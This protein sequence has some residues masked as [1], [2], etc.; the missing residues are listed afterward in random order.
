MRYKIIIAFFVIMLM[1][2]TSANSTIFNEQGFNEN[3][4]KTE[5]LSRTTVTFYS[6]TSDG[7]TATWGD[8]YN[9]IWSADSGD[10]MNW[11]YN[12]C[13]QGKSAHYQIQRA[14][15]YFD[16]SS[17]PD[18]APILSATLSL[19]GMNTYTDIDFYI[20]V[21]NGQPTYPHDPIQEGDYD[22]D[23]YS[24][25]GGSFHTSNFVT[26]AYNDI[27]LNS[28]GKSWIN[29]QGQTKFCLRSQ[30]EIEG[31][32]PPHLKLEFVSFYPAEDGNNFAPKLTV[33]YNS[34]PN[35]PSKPTGSTNGHVDTQYTY[36]STTSDPDNDN[37]YYW[38]DWGDGTNSGWKGP[39]SSGQPGS[40]S[41][42]WQTPGSYNVKV[43]SK[44]VHGTESSWSDPLIVTI[45]NDPP[46]APG[47]PNGP[48]SGNHGVQYCYSTSAT[49]PENQQVK[50]YFDWGDG[51]GAWT[52]FVNSGDSVQKCHT[53]SEP[54]SYNVKAKAKDELGEESGWSGILNVVLTNQAPNI[55]SSPDPPPGATWVSTSTD[56][57]WNGGDP[58]GDTVYYDVYFGTTNPPGKVNDDQTSTTY[59]P[60]GDLEELTIYYWQI[61]AKD[62][63]GYEVIGPI[64]SFTTREYNK[65]VLKLY[66]GWP[67][68]HIP[69]SGTQ[70]T[71]FTF[72]INYEDQDG[73]PPVE[74]K[75]IFN[76]GKEY[77]MNLFSGVP[78][79]GNYEVVIKGSDVGGGTHK[80]WFWYKDIKDEVRFPLPGEEWAIEVNHQPNKPTIS[81]PPNGLPDVEYVYSAETTD[82]E[83][84][85]LKYWFDWGDG[86]NS[87]WVPYDEWTSSGDMVSHPHTWS[88]R[89]TY[90]VK[91]RAMDKSEDISEWSEPLTVTMPRDR[92]T[93]YLIC[94]FYELFGNF[95][96]MQH[97]LTKIR[98]NLPS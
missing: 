38:F 46:N 97:I 55:P 3:K 51:T 43:K 19:Y 58:N 27:S 53:W 50:I 83:V 67:K 79:D 57:S 49:D 76:N 1:I 98:V 87:G 32:S 95:P 86:S 93:N 17:I 70:Q 65:P 35:K 66:G 47:K 14:Y 85:D 54:G 56:L 68:G 22:K 23:H 82:P 77:N 90:T 16:T 29:K 13:G 60:P 92:F 5:P 78:A 52:G 18:G 64:W 15:V 62:E 33:E 80:Y 8:N 4:N 69:D 63:Y 73:D 84:E 26:E 96:V 6:S 41:K 71:D 7:Y 11:F 25:E 39:Y 31:I 36:S 28:D 2:T 61:F 48:A 59:D 75:L 74:K 81:G 20:I 37:I 12:T 89:G 45:V 21:Q 24:G 30:R 42:T 44:D 34:P 88:K 91:V 10:V 40:A 9:E 72:R 94:K